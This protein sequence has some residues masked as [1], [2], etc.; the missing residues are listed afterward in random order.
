MSTETTD[1]HTDR[2]ASDRT[3]ANDAS[4]FG[5]AALR[6]LLEQVPLA[7]FMAD[8]QGRLVYANETARRDMAALPDIVGSLLGRAL[9]IGE[10][11]RNE[12]IALAGAAGRCR[13]ASVSVT[14]LYGD[15][16]AIDGAVLT[17]A[18]VTARKRNESWE[19][20]MESLARL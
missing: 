17:M 6:A 18:D 16:D 12:E 13:Y 19:P 10:F 1:R 11:V 5:P 20:L 3:S 4:C 14:P 7:V 15:G 9:L 8:R 2:S